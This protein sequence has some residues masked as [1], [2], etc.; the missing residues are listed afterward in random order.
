MLPC[1]E[2]DGKTLTVLEFFAVGKT[3]RAFLLRAVKGGG[4]PLQPLISAIFKVH[5]SLFFRLSFFI[6]Y[7][8][9]PPNIMIL[10]LVSIM[11]PYYKIISLPMNSRNISRF[12][13]FHYTIIL[14]SLTPNKWQ[15]SHSKYNPMFNALKHILTKKQ[16]PNAHYFFCHLLLIFIIYLHFFTFM[17]LQEP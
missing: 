1:C 6:A 13:M 3:F 2:F 16:A 5:L 11:H 8:T 7:L 10:R 9:L 17:L 14:I 12:P 4:R 15:N